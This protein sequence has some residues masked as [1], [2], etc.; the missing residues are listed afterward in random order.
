MK[1]KD[2]AIAAFLVSVGIFSVAQAI[3]YLGT[4]SVNEKTALFSV[5]KDSN[6]NILVC[7]SPVFEAGETGPK[8]G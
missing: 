3:Q 2:K 8:K 4:L 1:N 7:E 6:N 5:A